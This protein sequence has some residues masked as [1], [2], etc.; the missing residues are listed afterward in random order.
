MGKSNL[1]GELSGREVLAGV[2]MT[3]RRI[4]GWNMEFYI[5]GRCVGNVIQ[6]GS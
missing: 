2:F 1:Y 6:C 4:L 3:C 5:R